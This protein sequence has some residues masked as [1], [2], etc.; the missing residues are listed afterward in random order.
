MSVITSALL[1]H[2]RIL[3]YIG[4]SLALL[5]TTTS[6]ATVNPMQRGLAAMNNTFTTYV[7][8]EE[9]KNTSYWVSEQPPLS[10][11]LVAAGAETYSGVHTYPKLSV[12][13]K[14]FPKSTSIYNRYAHVQFYID[15]NNHTPTISLLQADSFQITLSD[16]SPI[17]K[18][19]HIDYIV[20]E[21]SFQNIC[22]TKHERRLF[23][24][25]I[26]HIYSR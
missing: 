21:R 6:S 18:D 8:N 19:L 26:L 4:L 16:C 2:Y 20:S 23:E 12:W 13:S 14:Y 7:K 24:N 25:K 22:F 17:L 11:M 3:R 9:S 5:F 15:Q 10:A 1:S